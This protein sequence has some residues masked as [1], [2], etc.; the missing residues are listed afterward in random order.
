MVDREGT[1]FVVGDGESDAVRSNAFEV[2][3]EGALG[4]GDLV[5]SGTISLDGQELLQ[6]ISRLQA[7]IDALQAELDAMIG[8][9]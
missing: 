3:S 5:V 8:G 7:Q 4:N 2:S 1:L 9:E 6:I